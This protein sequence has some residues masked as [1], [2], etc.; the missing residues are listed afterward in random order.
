MKLLV[1]E[2]LPSLEWGFLG[3]AGDLLARPNRAKFIFLL[4]L[5]LLLLLLT[6]RSAQLFTSCLN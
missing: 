2:I 1:E 3:L 4:L 6:F 5:L